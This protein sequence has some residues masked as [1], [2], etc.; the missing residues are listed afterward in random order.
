MKLENKAFLDLELCGEAVSVDSGEPTEVDIIDLQITKTANC[1]YA[2]LGGN[3]CYTVT[4]VNNSDVDFTDGEMG[5]ITF[6]DPLADN[7]EYV[8]D[9]F[10]YGT[11]PDNLTPG[12]P[13]ID[14]NNVITFDLAIPAGETMYIEFCAKVTAMPTAA[15]A[16]DA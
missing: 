16:D 14:G 2:I 3:I 12:T 9:S 11:D 10:E 1:A 13:N 7:L 6:R 5:E 15:A 4:I 8:D